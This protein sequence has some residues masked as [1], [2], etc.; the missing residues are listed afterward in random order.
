MANFVLQIVDGNSKEN[1][2]ALPDS[3]TFTIGPDPT[4]DDASPEGQVTEE[5]F[6]IDRTEVT[7]AQYAEFLNAAGNEGYFHTDMADPDLCGIVRTASRF[8]VVPG[9]DRYPIV[10]VNQP[11]AAAY[12]AWAG[13]RLPTEFEWEIAARGQEGRLYP[14]GDA[15]PTDQHTNFDFRVGHPTQVGSYPLGRTPGGVDDLLG[16]VWELVSDWYRTDY[17]RRA[18]EK[19]PKGPLFG[20]HHVLKGGSFHTE[21]AVHFIMRSA[22]R[23]GKK[24]HPEENP[25]FGFRCAKDV[26]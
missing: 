21:F 7:V 6:L 18:P 2:V 4:D 9:R 3:G 24:V 19:N 1:K 14:W 22:T 13:K 17:Y 8:D 20:S 25:A 15:A 26:D 5:D 10:Y 23:Y 16:N 11:M 12:A